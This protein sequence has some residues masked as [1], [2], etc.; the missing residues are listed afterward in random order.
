V[1]AE[2]ARQLA[3]QMCYE[4]T[5][6]VAELK[7]RGHRMQGVRDQLA[8][9]DGQPVAIVEYFHPRV[10]EFC[11]T[12]P[13]AMGA[14]LLR[15]PRLKSLFSTLF[16]KGYNVR[17]TSVSGYLLLRAVA[18]MKRWRRASY[19]Y[20]MQWQHIG[21]W[22]ARVDVALEEDYD[23]ALAVAAAVESVR[24]YGDTYERG[25]QRYKDNLEAVH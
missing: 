1:T 12:L 9:G 6:R 22:L 8:A 19:R 5:S 3:L 16:S 4:D 11:D 2:I 20:G 15:S 21:G 23:K 13:R 14:W 7:T 18:G 10:E 24:G 17:T 25:M